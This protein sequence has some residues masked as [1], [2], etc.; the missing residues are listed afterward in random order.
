MPQIRFLTTL[1]ELTALSQHLAGDKGLTCL[2]GRGEK[3]RG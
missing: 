2:E 1:G 3:G